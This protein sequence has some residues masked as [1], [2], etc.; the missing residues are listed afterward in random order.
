MKNELFLPMTLKEAQQWGWDSLDIVLVTGD[1]YVDH[2]SFGTALLGR[3]L[4][5]L[6]YKVGVIAQP[7]WREN[8]DF[9]KLGRPKLFF[10]VTAGNLDS[11]V[12]N[13]TAANKRRRDDAY[14]P[15]R[16]AGL[17][18]D[19]ATIV[20]SN[21]LKELFPDTPIVLGGIEASMRRIAHYDYWQNS[22]RR[23]ILFDA[24]ADLL[25]YGMGEKQIAAIAE[26]FLLGLGVE[27]CFG[28]RG[29]VH[30]EKD[31]YISKD[32]VVLPSFAAVQDKKEFGRAYKLFYNELD[33]FE[34]RVVVQEQQDGWYAV[35]NPPEKPMTAE[36]LDYI[37]GLPFQRRAHPSYADQG[38]VP[39]VKTTQFSI[40]T[41]RGCPGECYFCSLALHQ[42]RVVQSR[43]EKSILQEAETIASDPEFRG[44]IS[45]AGGPSA[46]LYGTTC[47][48]QAR[49][50]VCKHRSC[51]TPKICPNLEIDQQSYVK[52][53]QNIAKVPSVKRVFVQS[54]VRFDA[55]LKDAGFMKELI[56]NH[57]SGQLKVAPEHVSSRV[58]RQ[59]NK[60][61]HPVYQ[62]FCRKYSQIS[63][64]LGKEPYV[65]PYLISS[66]PGSTLNDAIELALYIKKQGRFFE[67]VQDFIP[68]PLTV[69]GTM[70]YTGENPF[71]GEKVHI[72]DE[73]EKKMQR[74]LLQFQD[75]RNWPLVRKALR[76]AKR[77]DLI[78]TGKNCLVPGETKSSAKKR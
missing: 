43:S 57:V 60:P 2:P 27:A 24:K 55:A 8:E 73:E 25:V 51:M 56:R 17:R 63:L 11:M 61:A 22:V 28:L 62:E 18:P 69:S 46:N 39:A 77:E 1:A 3:Y 6:G 37:Y 59:M 5:S 78:G 4:V 74:A 48:L 50:G 19:R 29:T 58:L 68:L 7:N 20:Y 47:K 40:T 53:L 36:E 33:P 10:G 67:Q 71:T 64:D 14:A 65:I 42:G 16:K 49:R 34:G 13:Y 54:G 44:T 75:R 9:L 12:A 72:P 23:S 66:H 30:K 41:H 38:G 21:K 76:K 52:L 31:P 45:D 32:T 15:G 35:V 26:N 70:W